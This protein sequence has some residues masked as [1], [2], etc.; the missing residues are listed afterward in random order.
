M[1]YTI[2]LL[3]AT[4]L[5]ASAHAARQVDFANAAGTVAGS[6]SGLTLT[7]STLTLVRN[8]YSH[9]IITGNLGT[10]EFSTAAM[11]SGNLNILCYP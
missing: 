7:G 9:G 3:M 5:P 8:L 10:V 1:K 11:D 2:V 4:L 6:S